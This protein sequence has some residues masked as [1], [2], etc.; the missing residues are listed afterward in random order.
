M[1][2]KVGLIIVAGSE[3]QNKCIWPS[4]KN[5]KTSIFHDLIVVH[6]NEK[7]LSND[8]KNTSGGKVIFENKINKDGIELPHKAFGAYREYWNKYKNN[9]DLFGFISDDV[10]IKRDHWLEKVSDVIFSC[11]KL[12][13][14]GTQIFNGSNGE[15]PH[16]SHCR[17]PIWFGKSESLKK[18][19]WKFNSD[20]DGEMK[21]AEQFLN[22]GFFGCQ[23]GNKIDLAYDS[24][25]KG[26][27]HIG[28]HISA[29][30]ETQLGS[31]ISK[32]IAND[33]IKQINNQL[34]NKLINGNDSDIV[35]SPF[36]HI[37]PRKLISQLQPFDGLIF[38]KS[39]SLADEYSN[40]YKYNIMILKGCSHD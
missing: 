32:K 5:A 6:R 16:R 24:T 37:G 3:K 13:W 27:F 11:D 38:D 40:K 19:D 20:H 33:K 26:N 18:I 31:D 2:Y 39:K 7:H 36:K 1:S 21:I 29:I 15:Y 34:W 8:I 30:M 23:V 9:Y 28:D 14:C 35:K 25:E 22:A 17:A 12:G 10:L 4:Y